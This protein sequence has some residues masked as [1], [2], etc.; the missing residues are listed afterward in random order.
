MIMVLFTKRSTKKA[1]SK[2]KIKVT[3]R[4]DAILRVFV[5]Q[6]WTSTHSL[7]RLD[8]YADGATHTYGGWIYLMLAYP[9]TDSAG[10]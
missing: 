7:D 5:L 4:N 9:Y 8:D 6:K 2:S 3:N 1:L 10:G